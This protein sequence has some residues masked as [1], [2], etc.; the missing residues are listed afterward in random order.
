MTQNTISRF[1]IIYR[2]DSLH[3]YYVNIIF[4]IFTNDDLE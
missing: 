2:D 4:C 3:V 1:H